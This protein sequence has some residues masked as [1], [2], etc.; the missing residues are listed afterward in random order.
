MSQPFYDL[1]TFDLPEEISILGMGPRVL[2]GPSELFF[3]GMPEGI[4]KKSRK[5]RG[6]PVHAMYRDLACKRC[7]K[8]DELAALRRGVDPS[9]QVP[10]GPDMW[11]SSEWL[12]VVSVP[13]LECLLS[14]PG[15]DLE[16]FRIP[17]TDRFRIIYPRKLFLPDGP[18]PLSSPITRQTTPFQMTRGPCKVCGRVSEISIREEL[19]PIS[20]DTVLAGMKGEYRC[21]ST[22]AIIVSG[23]V[24]EALRKGNFSGWRARKLES[25]PHSMEYRH[26]APPT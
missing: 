2:P 14:V 26:G 20:P 8:L 13:F 17:S 6:R 24:V 5:N 25:G 10:D 9:V 1:D 23:A 3:F 4:S 18:L 21:C 16:V 11:V 22:L 12:R 7:G 19:Y 15:V